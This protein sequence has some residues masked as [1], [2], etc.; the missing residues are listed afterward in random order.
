M[1]RSPS[2]HIHS[3]E[4]PVAMQGLSGVMWVPMGTEQGCPAEQGWALW[5]DT[6]VV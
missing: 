2:P 4:G 6:L 1:G 3:R 5:L